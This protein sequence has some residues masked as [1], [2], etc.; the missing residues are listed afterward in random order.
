MFTLAEVELCV[1]RSFFEH[2]VVI[3]TLRHPTAEHG[4]RHENSSMNLMWESLRCPCH[5]SSS[6]T[7]A[8]EYDLVVTLHH[9]Q[10]QIVHRNPLLTAFNISLP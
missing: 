8:H 9:A 5:T 10:R 2:L 1:S 7:V 3:V 4:T 6:H